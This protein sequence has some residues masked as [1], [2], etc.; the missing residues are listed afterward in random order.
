V[1]VECAVR[2]VRRL[3]Q[4][5]WIATPAGT[6]DGV[7][8]MIALLKRMRIGVGA[9]IY[10]AIA[11]IVVLTVAASIVAL[12]S[13]GRVTQTVHSLFDEHYPVVELSRELAQV[14]GATVAM[15]PKLAEVVVDNDRKAVVG[16]L[17][18][19]TARMRGIVDALHQRNAIDRSR[20]MGMIDQLAANIQQMD[21]AARQRIA[22][23]VQKAEVAERLSRARVVFNQVL[24]NA[25]DE[26]QFALVF[27]LQ[28]AGE[29]A[30]ADQL[31]A[32][33][34]KLAEQELSRYGTS[35]ML[36][37]ELNQAYGLLREALAIDRSEQI[38][39]TQSRFKDLTASVDKT[40]QEAESKNA[41]TNRRTVTQAILAFGTG[42][43]SVFNLREREFGN[44]QAIAN[45][46]A[47]LTEAANELNAEIDRIV[48]GARTA[49]SDATQSTFAMMSNSGFWL[50]LIAAA[51]ILAAAAIAIFFVRPKIVL[52]L[53]RLSVAT[54]AIAEGELD[55][56]IG[57]N[58][59]DEIGDVAGAVRIFRDNAIEK[60]RI[61][62]EA[63]EQQSLA[64]EERTRNEQAREAAAR[65]VEMVVS[66]L[67][68]ALSA[69]AEGDLLVRLTDQCAPEYEKVKEDFN[70]ALTTLQDTI[71][72]IRSSALEVSNA[73]AEISA[74]TTDLSQRTEEQAASLE[75]TTSSL[76]R[77]A[78]TVRKNAERA[79]QANELAAKTRTVAD[80][81][82]EVVTQAMSAMSRIE[83]S[84]REISDIINLIDEIARQT[85]LLALN[86]AVEAARAGEAG[87][88]F[89]VVASE[90]RS[91]AQRSAE[92]AKG[93]R[94]L[95]TSSSGRVQ[96]GVEFVNRAG[97]ALGDIV[98]SIK[99]VVAIVSE[100]ATASA[101]QASGIEEVNKA[102]TQMDEVTQQNSALVEE[103]A[104]TAQALRQQA[105]EMSERVD[106][107]QLSAQVAQRAA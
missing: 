86:A 29:I 75:E 30:D 58:G 106:F 48:L 11:A 33:L 40:L 92:A 52:R 78:E 25:V 39:Y 96:E 19:G 65:Q 38:N 44:R 50:M 18:E 31:K 98:E 102:L 76:M 27:G 77:I 93:I 62:R 12:L 61:E 26:T 4:L 99:H 14:A 36:L 69:V 7:G 95:I 100:I 49:A 59:S 23:E 54:R 28:S 56:R 13:F 63:Q 8:A 20:L 90:V 64:A 68:A 84:S 22:I 87:R 80:R 66:M 10:L 97:S 21:N 55:T 24:S 32:T 74:S 46:L 57:D 41:D 5:G 82:G 104:A 73:S 1:P 34:K 91:L 51:S 94:D 6:Q 79:K 45:N 70:A 17:E 37:A 101:E 2:R 16:R 15:A 71:C 3:K 107:F 89:A 81:G 9:R 53:R 47:A 67:G 43:G 105:A 42:G 85:N 103:N 35:L 83:E 88:G 60:I 72:A